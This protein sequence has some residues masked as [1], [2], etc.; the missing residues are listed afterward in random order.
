MWLVVAVVLMPYTWLILT[1]LNFE[2]GLAALRHARGRGPTPADLPYPL[3]GSVAGLLTACY[4][5]WAFCDAGVFGVLAQPLVWPLILLPDLAW[6][7]P[8][9]VTRQLSDEPRHDVP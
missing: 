8:S 2:A 1:R 7:L 6:I 5:A 4:A 3:C 9:L